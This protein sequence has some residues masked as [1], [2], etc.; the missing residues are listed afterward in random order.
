MANVRSVD[1]HSNPSWSDLTD[2]ASH[3]ATD[4]S[5]LCLSPE[6]LLNF[7]SNLQIPENVQIYGVKITGK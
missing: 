6:S 3:I 7:L 5:K 2:K 4:L 1:Y